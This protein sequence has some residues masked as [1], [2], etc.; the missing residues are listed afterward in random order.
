M[1]WNDLSIR[2]KLFTCFGTLVTFMVISALLSGSAFTLIEKNQEKLNRSVALSKECSQRIT[3]HYIWVTRVYSSILDDEK[4]EVGVETNDHLC[5]LGKWLYGKERTDLEKEIPE[6]MEMLKSIEEPHRLLHLSAIKIDTLLKGKSEESHHD[7]LTE[8]GKI[9]DNETFPVLKSVENSMHEILAVLQER[10]DAMG[11]TISQA[12]GTKRNMGMIIAFS[13]VVLAVLIGYFMSRSIIA[14]L[15]ALKEFSGKIASGDLTAKLF[16]TSGDE[17]GQL[18]DSL[19]QTAIA[20]SR[21]ISSVISEVGRLTSFS[22]DLFTVSDQ[23]AGGASGMS[24][25]ASTVAAAAETMSRNMKTVAGVTEESSSNIT[26]VAA[27]TE[28]ITSSVKNIS[29]RLENA[30]TIT[31]SAVAKAREASKKVTDLGSAASEISNVTEAITEISEQTN[32]LA[33]NATIEAARA[34][35]A[36]KGFAVVAN[37]IK[38]LAK[39]TAQATRDIKD[40]VQ[41]IQ[42]GTEG[43]SLEI[44]E[45]SEVIHQVNDI[46]SSISSS[47]DEQAKATSEIAGNVARASL[48]MKEVNENVVKCA[49]VSSKIAE[50]I[51]DVSQIAEDIKKGSGDVNGKAEDVSLSASAAKETAG[52]FRIG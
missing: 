52:I 20:I 29:D 33:L 15:G 51:T 7:I 12:I 44:K 26:I 17:F 30:R 31:Y 32:L 41:G 42:T 2:T 36:G 28:E 19:R 6:V 48:G 11:K 46:V 9:L 49:Q 4:K 39:Q 43:T 3:D 5:R 38:E 14:T 27:A 8:A 18:A 40:K 45:I 22:K 1:S 47:M 37:E 35:E 50:D 10:Q 25:R 34:G 16:H 13:M 23:L 21:I 24:E